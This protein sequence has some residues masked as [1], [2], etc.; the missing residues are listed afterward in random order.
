MRK[1]RKCDFR[2]ISPMFEALHVALVTLKPNINFDNIVQPNHVLKTQP[3]EK[4][5][6]TI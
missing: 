1:P 6:N 4:A 5:N 3:Y 2:G